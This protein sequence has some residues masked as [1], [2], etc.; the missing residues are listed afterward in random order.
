[1]LFNTHV[2]IGSTLHE[3]LERRGGV[4]VPRQAFLYGHIKPDLERKSEKDRHV[5]SVTQEW[6]RDLAGR[7]IGRSMHAERD[8]KGD[9]ILLGELCHHICDAFCRYHFDADLYADFGRHFLYEVGL[10]ARYLRLHAYGVFQSPRDGIRKMRAERVEVNPQ[11]T[12]SEL[13]R[14]VKARLAAYGEM[15]PSFDLDIR[16]ALS[17]SQRAVELICPYLVRTVLEEQEPSTIGFPAERGTIAA[18]EFIFWR[19][20][21]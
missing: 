12:L 13:D 10:H 17:A 6:I 11:A 14:H 16:Y 8:P 21:I 18:P 2:R 5:F 1:M 19:D 4:V 9:A 15:E 3:E 20:A 7:I